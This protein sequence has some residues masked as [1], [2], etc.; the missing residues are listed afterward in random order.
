MKGGLIGYFILHPV[1][2]IS[3]NL[4]HL[5][6]EEGTIHIHSLFE[7]L[8][9]ILMAFEPFMFWWAGT[10]TA[11]GVA[12]GIYYG[13]TINRLDMLNE[14]LEQEIS[15]RKQS[16]KELQLLQKINNM[17]I[18]TEVKQE[19]V[20]KTIV[21]GIRLLYGYDSVAI[22]LLSNDRKYLIIKNYSA[23]FKIAR[24]LEKLIGTMIIGFKAPLYKG[25][26]LH[27]IV[28]KKKSIITDDIEWILKSYTN[29]K[30]L[31]KMAKI[32]AQLT[33]SNWGIGMPLTANGK[34]VGTIGCGSIEK[35]SEIKIQK[36][37]FF[38]D[39]AGLAIENDLI[40]LR[41]TKAEKKYRTLV[42]SATDA[43]IHI[44]LDQKIVLWN[45]AAENLFGYSSN[46]IIG[47][48]VDI[49]I[50][51]KYLAAHKKGIERF[52][53]TG[54]A[55]LIGKTVEIEAKRK[56]GSLF[57]IEIS[58]SVEKND[59]NITF[60]SIIRDITKRKQTEKSLEK[61]SDELEQSNRLKDIFTDIMTH[62]LINPAGII[63]NSTELGLNMEKDPDKRKFLEITS[64][65]SERLI[66]MIE[67]ASILAKL[68]SGEEM[69]VEDQDLGD[70]LKN[71][72]AQM[73]GLADEKK[74]KIKITAKGKFK[75]TVN[76]LIYDLFLN[77]ISNAIKYGPENSSVVIMIEENDTNWRISVA[78]SGPGIP[79]EYKKEIF[80]RFTRLQ[81]QGVKGTGLGL[82]IAKK[83]VKF[84]SG[85]IWVEDNPHG[86]S[87]FYVKL[88]KEKI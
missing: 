45:T 43:I 49:I 59:E 81:K 41:L 63:K 55:K 24:K 13:T 84:H 50:P 38:G 2:M 10:F 26:A 37:K 17:L 65:A 54:K 28:D 33:K 44:T 22:H 11:F 57:P 76:P 64:T 27:D 7:I 12:L 34:V 70:I 4:M 40:T 61:Y 23:D 51:K 71:A 14:K 48:S 78:D 86:G 73:K 29:R 47:Q 19:T 35:P 83:V 53:R 15:V 39:Q 79:D 46:E 20:F 21:D 82:A 85:K 66:S 30:S 62:D 5:H 31:Q 58:L 9:W 75:A 72:A 42:Q 68:E 80:D 52:V 6:I 67:N 36:L 32:A 60:T 1:V 18:S 25:S 74:M 77:L 8:S 88:P 16:N 56:D 69:A 87:I 3:T